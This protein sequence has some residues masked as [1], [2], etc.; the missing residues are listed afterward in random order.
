[1]VS[2]PLP[3][4]WLASTNSTS[5]P[6]GG[7]ARPTTPPADLDAAQNFL[8]DLLGDYQLV[9]LPFR[10]AARLF[11]ANGTDGAFEVADARFAR[12][13]TDDVADRF[14]REF[15][16]LRRDSVF[17]DLPR[18]QVLERNVDFLFLGVTLQFDDLHAVAQGL[19]DRI[20]HV[21]G[22][23]EQDFREIETHVQIVVAERRVLLGIERFEQRR[24]R[25]AAEVASHLVNFIEH[26]DGVFGLRAPY[27]LNDL[28]GQGSDV[29]AAVA[30][31]L[32]FVVHS[33]KR[34]THELAA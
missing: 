19:G 17:F 22:G 25:I 1:M 12:V 11:A 23:D 18:N 14:F 20:E 30:A 9:G 2:P 21:R 13:V 5:P 16:L 8:H 24:R 6:D 3:F 10:Q 29:G 31:N 32:G 27:A 34:Q 33:A 7:H 15:D 4:I 28:A 26:E